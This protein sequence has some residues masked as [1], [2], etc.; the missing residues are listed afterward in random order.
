MRLVLACL[1]L[2]LTAPSAGAAAVK[3]TPLRFDVANVN[4]SA[5]P[6]SADGKRYVLRGRLVAPAD[7][8]GRAVTLYLHEFSFAAHFWSF[9]DE[10]YDYAAALARTGQASVVIDRLGYGASATPDG[11]ATCLGAQADMA[12]QIVEQLRARGY[13]RV[14][15]AGHSVGAAVAELAYHSFG[16]VDA[17][18]LFGWAHTGYTAPALRES[19]I[20]GGVCARGGEPKR[21]GGAGGYAFYG[22]SPDDLKGLTF[23]D[24]EPAIQQRMAALRERDPCGDAS[25]LTPTVAFDGSRAGDVKVPV[26]LVMGENDGV[27]DPGTGEKQRDAYTGSDDVTLYTQPRAAHALTLEKTAPQMRTAV[28]AWLDRHRFDDARAADAPA[29][30]SEPGPAASPRPKVKQRK[31]K[32]RAKRCAKKRARSRR[33]DGAHRKPACRA[34]AR[35]KRARRTRPPGRRAAVS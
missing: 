18:A 31:A 29:D 27:Y 15:L 11:M 32:K 13:K 21:E 16:A 28:A 4:R 5:L 12:S 8:A 34:R 35:S 9:P 23:Y 25:S 2:L 1:L 30:R 19:F 10:R 20:Q 33:R 7:D 17:L 24:P 6:C 3:T 14:A 22:Q 26:L